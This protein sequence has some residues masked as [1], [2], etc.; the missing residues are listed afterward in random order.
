MSKGTFFKTFK[1][2]IVEA[3]SVIEVYLI[4]I[5]CS[6][7]GCGLWEMTRDGYTGR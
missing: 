5:N 3:L 6:N 4:Q 2:H 1:N 7:E